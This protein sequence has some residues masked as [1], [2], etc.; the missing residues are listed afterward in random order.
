MATPP[1]Q[2]AFS[3]RGTETVLV[4]ED[5]FGVRG[6]ITQILKSAGY[7]VLAAANGGEALLICERFDGPIHLLLTDIVMPGMSGRELAGRLI[8]LRPDLRVLHISGYTD[9]A[10][11][12][13][14]V[15]QEHMHFIQK[16]FTPRALT[17]KVREVLSAPSEPPS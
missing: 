4:V 7:R 11:L 2:P 17:R 6:L 5:E 9:K 1:E 12:E 13:Y 15:L 14:G 16:P 3:E 8:R 10:I